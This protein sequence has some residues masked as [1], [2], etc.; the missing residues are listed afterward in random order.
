[1]KKLMNFLSLLLIA[2]IGFVSCKKP[3]PIEPVEPK[4]NCVE[5]ATDNERINA[6]KKVVEK[7]YPK[8]AEWPFNRGSKNYRSITNAQVCGIE[9]GTF[10]NDGF[11][12]LKLTLKTGEVVLLAD[13]VYYVE[14]R[15]IRINGAEETTLSTHEWVRP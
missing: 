12:G 8:M 2:A 5:Y 9:N 14:I 7:H 13:L 10:G 3:A 1:M 15:V 6:L 4:P 11:G